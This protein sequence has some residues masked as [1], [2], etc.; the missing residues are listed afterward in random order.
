MWDFEDSG[1][2]GSG[3]GAF[4]ERHRWD[5]QRLEWLGAVY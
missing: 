4:Q 3:D 1:I 5:H 2:Q